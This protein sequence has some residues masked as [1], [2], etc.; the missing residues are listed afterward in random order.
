M[1]EAQPSDGIDEAV[2]MERAHAKAATARGAGDWFDIYTEIVEMGVKKVFESNGDGHL[3]LEKLA[4]RRRDAAIVRR[5][6][7]AHGLALSEEIQCEGPEITPDPNG[8]LTQY[9][10][11]R[12][13]WVHFIWPDGS[14][15]K[16]QGTKSITALGFVQWW[17]TFHLHYKHLVDP[18]APQKRRIIEAHTPEWDAYMRAKARDQ[19]N[20]LKG[21]EGK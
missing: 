12:G 16:F 4:P 9:S 2:I 11:P 19:A 15:L 5:E 13:L 20:A 3:V 21:P 1:A 6:F 17:T 18:S 7:V 14:I 10:W 8:Q